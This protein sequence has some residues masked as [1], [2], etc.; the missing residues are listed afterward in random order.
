MYSNVESFQYIRE[1]LEKTLVTNLEQEDRLPFKGLPLVTIF[2]PEPDLDDELL[3]K[4]HSE[5]QNLAD[6]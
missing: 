3:L 4:L 2:S 6:R 1:S 5:G